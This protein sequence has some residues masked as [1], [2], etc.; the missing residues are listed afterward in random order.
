VGRELAAGSQFQ[1]RIHCWIEPVDNRV[2]AVKANSRGA[3]SDWE[4]V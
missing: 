2:S 3:V 1:T 4:R